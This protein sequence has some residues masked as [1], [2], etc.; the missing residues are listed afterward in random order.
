MEG[1]RFI[2]KNGR[3]IPVRAKGGSSASVPAKQGKKDVALANRKEQTRLEGSSYK[4]ATAAGALGGFTARAWSK[5]IGRV[6]NRPVIAPHG[7]AGMALALGTAALSVGSTVQQFRAAAKSDSV[8]GG[9]LNLVKTGFIGSGASFL[10]GLAGRA[11]GAG[12]LKG[13]TKLRDLIRARK[14]RR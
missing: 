13:A 14:A 12:S 8:G 4:F 5:V 2:R 10:G 3:V 11:V 7:K 1:V 9:V 6:G